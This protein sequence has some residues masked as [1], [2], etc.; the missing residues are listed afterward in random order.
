MLHEFRRRHAALG[1]KLAR[2]IARAHV[3]A[4]GEPFDGVVFV[5]VRQDPGLQLANVGTIGRLG[6]K[7]NAELVLS[8]GP[9][10]K[11]D[12]HARDETRRF[13]T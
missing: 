7:K 11:H 9:A 4:C 10:Q 2:E 6:L 1:E 8:A 12:H 5:G 13:S 3:E